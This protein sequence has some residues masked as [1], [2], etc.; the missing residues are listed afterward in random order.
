MVKPKKKRVCVESQAVKLTQFHSIV[1]ER[2]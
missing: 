2:I 1:E